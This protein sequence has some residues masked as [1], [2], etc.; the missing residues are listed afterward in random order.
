MLVFIWHPDTLF[1]PNDI[2]V[3]TSLTCRKYRQTHPF[4]RPQ[5]GSQCPLAIM[6]NSLI[7]LLS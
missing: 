3:G 2:L 6:Y 1:Q 7:S 4:P 5:T